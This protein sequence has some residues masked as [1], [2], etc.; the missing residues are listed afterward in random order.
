MRNI[1]LTKGQRTSFPWGPE[2]TVNGA[3]YAPPAAEFNREGQAFGQAYG[4]DEILFRAR[5]LAPEWFSR[6]D[7]TAG[8]VV[9]RFN[10][11]GRHPSLGDYK[12][13]LQWFPV[14]RCWQVLT[15]SEML[16]RTDAARVV[17]VAAKSA[18]GLLNRVLQ[19][20]TS[21]IKQLPPEEQ[22]QFVAEYERVSTELDSLQEWGRDV[23]LTLADATNHQPQLGNGNGQPQLMAG[24]K[25]G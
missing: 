10:L 20:A 21:V 17:G 12:F 7:L 24:K 18:Q 6:R 5:Q 14:Q 9:E 22:E 11:G 15:A 19:M 8:E 23:R 4:A 2:S 16:D 25:K 1:Q 3:N 13:K